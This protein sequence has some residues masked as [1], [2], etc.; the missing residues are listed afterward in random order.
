[1]IPP[2]FQACINWKLACYLTTSIAALRFF[3]LSLIHESTWSDPLCQGHRV[4]FATLIE[5]IHYSKWSV[6]NSRKFGGYCVC[7]RKTNAALLFKG[8]YLFHRT[9][10]TYLMFASIPTFMVNVL[11]SRIPN[12]SCKLLQAWLSEQRLFSK[13]CS[14]GVF[15][16]ALIFLRALWFL[17]TATVKRIYLKG[18]TFCKGRIFFLKDHFESS[19]LWSSAPFYLKRKVVAGHSFSQSSGFFWRINLSH[20]FFHVR[21][22]VSR[23]S[24]SHPFVQGL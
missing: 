23:N 9:S 19:I 12:S 16:L 5:T 14:F 1:M 18:R 13:G 11:V 15:S 20:P 3:Y 17:E 2:W 22:F 6:V 24:C 8:G 4:Y 7:M 21:W 10:C